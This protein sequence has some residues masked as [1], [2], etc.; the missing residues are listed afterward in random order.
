MKNGEYTAE[1]IDEKVLR[2]VDAYIKQTL[3]YTKVDYIKELSNERKYTS[4][5]KKRNDG[6]LTSIE[7]ESDRYIYAEIRVDDY[8]IEFESEMMFR[9]IMRLTEKQR[10]VLLKNVVLGIPMAEI[11]RQMGIRE[12]KVYKHKKNALLALAE[13]MKPDEL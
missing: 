8:I 9:E 7:A 6:L 10:E 5:L 1:D 13:R 3:K 11:A 12:N 2:Y 4:L